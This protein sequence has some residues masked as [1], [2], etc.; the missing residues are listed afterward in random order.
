MHLHRQK[1]SIIVY[2]LQLNLVFYNCN[3]VH[4][5]AQ[6]LVV[7]NPS[8]FT[9]LGQWLNAIRSQ[10]KVVNERP[11]FVFWHCLPSFYFYFSLVLD[12]IFFFLSSIVLYNTSLSYP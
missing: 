1:C 6:I 3:A 10:I 5:G 8:Y 12:K 11:C 9:P 2:K 4:I 7:F